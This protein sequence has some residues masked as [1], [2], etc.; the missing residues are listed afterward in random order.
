MDESVVLISDNSP[1]STAVKMLLNMKNV[2]YIEVKYDELPEVEK[3]SF[4]NY[5]KPVIVHGSNDY[6]EGYD[7]DKLAKLFS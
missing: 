6:I 3:E 1:Q 7:A 4:Q 2:N 5:K